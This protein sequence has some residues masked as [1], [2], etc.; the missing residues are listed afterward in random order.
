ML[1]SSEGDILDNVTKNMSDIL[2]NVTQDID[3]GW[4]EEEATA[5]LVLE[6]ILLPTI[7]SFGFLG[8][9]F[10]WIQFLWHICYDG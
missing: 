8:N 6:G 7:S 2:D 10:L 9:V 1:N 4:G 3:Q 5:K